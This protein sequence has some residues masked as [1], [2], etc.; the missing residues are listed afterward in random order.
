MIVY[1]LIINSARHTFSG[2][3]GE[4]RVQLLRGGAIAQCSVVDNGSL[5]ATATSGRGLKIIDA[6]SRS[7]GGCIIQKFGPLGSRSILTFSCDIELEAARSGA[8]AH[9]RKIDRHR[10]RLGGGGTGHGSE[11]GRAGDPLFAGQ[12]GRRWQCACRRLAIAE[13][14]RGRE[15]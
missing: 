2:G 15:A 3:D 6:L 13:G 5:A 1:E 14:W 8:A 10:G 12:S 9:L 7:L 11:G 4:I